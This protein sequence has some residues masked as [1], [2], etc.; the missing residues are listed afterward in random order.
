MQYEPEKKH[1]IVLLP[2]SMFKMFWN[3][4]IIVMV[5]YTASISPYR[6]AFADE[7]VVNGWSQF[8]AL[9]EILIDIIFGI[10]I[11]INFISA[12]EDLD[13]RY[14]VSLKKIAVEY[15]KGFFMLDVLATF[16]FQ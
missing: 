8:F 3:L 9:F 6:L 11:I 10:D 4:L 7:F 13:G 2:N 16:P 14:E 15:I 12:Y 5:L 1:A